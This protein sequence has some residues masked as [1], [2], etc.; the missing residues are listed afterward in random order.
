[1]EAKYTTQMFGNEQV[2]RSG[3]DYI[4][5]LIDYDYLPHARLRLNKITM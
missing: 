4:A 1:V 5:N 3:G 2:A